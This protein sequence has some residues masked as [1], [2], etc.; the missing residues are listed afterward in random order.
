MI[1]G[2]PNP[3]NKLQL[4]HKCVTV[5]VSVCAGVYKDST[6][7]Y[8]EEVKGGDGAQREGKFITPTIWSL[9]NLNKKKK[10]NIWFLLEPPKNTPAQSSESF[11]TFNSFY[12]WG[13]KRKFKTLG[14]VGT[15]LVL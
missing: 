10:Q 1:R 3:K 6:A 5:C 4:Q 8:G 11:I 12:H 13:G 14:T 9:Y 7:L 15:F 2:L